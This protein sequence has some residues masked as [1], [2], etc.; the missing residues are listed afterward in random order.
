MDQA[1]LHII[2]NMNN[3]FF[4]TL[5]IQKP[6]IGFEYEKSEGTNA[7]GY[8][9]MVNDYTL[10]TLPDGKEQFV[11]DMVA[12]GE[13]NYPVILEYDISSVVDGKLGVPGIFKLIGHPEN[14]QQIVDEMSGVLG[15]KT[16]KLPDLPS[17]TIYTHCG[18]F[19]GRNA[20]GLRLN[21][22][23]GP[24]N[25]KQFIL[26][27]G[28]NPYWF[29]Q[30]EHYHAGYLA[31]FDLIDGEVRKMRLEIHPSVRCREIPELVNDP[32][33]KEVWDDFESNIKDVFSNDIPSHYSISH[34]KVDASDDLQTDYMKLYTHCSW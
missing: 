31:S 5:P 20:P 15:I 13:T 21:V 28:G 29:D 10:A 3:N 32:W 7:T 16:E 26:D 9:A 22:G 6:T 24:H 19:L 2:N 14:T 11:N 8:F 27:N 23:G 12:L 34:F 33:A 4:Y 30:F 18:A 25:I 1:S 17:G